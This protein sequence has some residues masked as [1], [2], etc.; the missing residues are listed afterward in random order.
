MQSSNIMWLDGAVFLP[1]ILLC[2][3][4]LCQGKGSLGLS[5]VIGA[6]ILSNWYSAGMNCLFSFFWLLFEILLRFSGKLFRKKHELCRILCQYFLHMLLGVGLSAVLFLPTIAAFQGN[7]EGSLQWNLFSDPGFCGNPLTAAANYCYGLVS[8]Y[9]SPVLYAGMLPLIAC[10]CFF[11]SRHQSRRKKGIYGGLLAFSVILMLYWKPL[12]LA[13]SLFKPVY[14]YW[15]RYSNMSI[16]V[17]LV[18]GAD[19]L[20]HSRQEPAW[21]PI[22]ASLL[23]GLA[24]LSLHHLLKPATRRVPGSSLGLS[25][26]V[27]LGMGLLLCFFLLSSRTPHAPKTKIILLFALCIASCGDLNHQ[28]FLMLNVLNHENAQSLKAYTTDTNA[29]LTALK[30]YR[31]ADTTMRISQTSTRIMK[32]NRL[33]ANYNEAL[34]YGYWSLSGYTSCPDDAQRLF[35]DKIGYRSNGTTFNIVNTSLAACDSLMGVKYVLSD[36]PLEGYIRMDKL[37]TGGSRSIYQNPYALPMAFVVPAS[38]QTAVRESDFNT[39]SPFG[40]VNYLYSCLLG[41]KT[42]LYQPLSGKIVQK[43]SIVQEENHPMAL[44]VKLPEGNFISYGLLPW[45]SQMN[46]ILEVDHLYRIGYGGWLS[47]S[48]F[49]IP[50]SKVPGH[51]ALLTVN[52]TTPY[53]FEYD[54]F[55]FSA[56]DLNQLKEISSFFTRRQPDLLDWK[57][58]EV[59]VEVSD[60]REGDSLFVSL[61]YDKGWTISCNGETIEAKQLG[62]FYLLPL[63]KGENRVQLVYHLPWLKQGALVSFLS[64]TILLILLWNKH[65]QSHSDFGS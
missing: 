2:I 51:E 23:F 10:I 12:C 34:A 64:L 11:L 44:K 43:G 31:A 61:P 49:P 19:F 36:Y 58:G 1:L 3:N 60:A 40:Y 5:L 20:V 6:G 62:I 14:S 26:T 56:L 35:L 27:L 33:T 50:A 59:F 18:I 9:G 55:E 32:K 22:L 41:K 54:N 7:E 24:L 15:Y 29:L 53:S 4:R 38:H 21:L 46:A 17:I 48:V 65:S 13:F 25:L 8:S 16:L 37:S 57:N 63:Q 47:S 45:S 30:E 52:S 39:A 28:C 42:L